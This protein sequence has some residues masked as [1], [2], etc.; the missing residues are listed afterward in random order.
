MAAITLHANRLRYAVDVQVTSGK[1]TVRGAIVYGLGG[2]EGQ[3]LAEGVELKRL[4]SEMSEL[5]QEHFY[6]QIKASAARALTKASV[7]ILKPRPQLRSAHVDLVL[8]APKPKAPRLP[9]PKTVKS[10]KAKRGTRV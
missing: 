10:G 3:L 2:E 4:L 9:K 5:E 6:V 1:T 8:P 7:E